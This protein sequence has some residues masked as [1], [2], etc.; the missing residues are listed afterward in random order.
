MQ[1]PQSGIMGLSVVAALFLALAGTLPLA[2]QERIPPASSVMPPGY[3]QAMPAA[4]RVLSDMKVADSVETRARQHAAVFDLRHILYVLTWDH[5]YVQGRSGLTPEE[6]SLNRG[7]LD[8]ENQLFHLSALVPGLTALMSRYLES[9][10]FRSQ[11]LD[12]YFSPAWKTAFRTLEAQYDER[13][14]ALDAANAAPRGEA[15]APPVSTALGAQAARRGPPAFDTSLVRLRPQ[16]HGDDLAAIYRAFG[17]PKGEFETTAQFQR[18]VANAPSPRPF[19]FLL[20][21]DEVSTEYNADAAELTVHLQAECQPEAN[22]IG[23][24]GKLIARSSF[25]S[26]ESRLIGAADYNLLVSCPEGEIDISYPVH[27]EPG[28]ARRAQGHT[29]AVLVG[30]PAL[31]AEGGYTRLE[32]GGDLHEL[33][34]TPLSL[35]MVNTSTGEVLNKHPFAKVRQ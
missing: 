25:A 7:Y 24:M 33:H 19:A 8:A 12:R 2:A 31:L 20:Q 28:A 10:P 23:N 16:Y 32:H 13:E 29:G 9:A 18:R 34:I 6:G 35:W 1:K 15:P 30:A 27:L 3:L 21:G 22:G 17:E 14:R 26:N 4:D 11:L 5:L